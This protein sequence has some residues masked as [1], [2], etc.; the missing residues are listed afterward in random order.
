MTA[1]AGYVF[2]E[3]RMFKQLVYIVSASLLL[4]ACVDPDEETGAAEET[5]ETV[6]A[7][8][9]GKAD[10]ASCDSALFNWTDTWD[11]WTTEALDQCGYNDSSLVG[12]Y[13]VTRFD[14]ATAMTE[15]RAA[16]G[17]CEV[18]RI[19]ST[20]RE[21]GI[22]LFVRP[23][24]TVSLIR[25]V[26][27]DLLFRSG[28]VSFNRRDLDSNSLLQHLVVWVALITQFLGDEGEDVIHIGI[29]VAFCQCIGAVHLCSMPTHLISLNP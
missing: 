14:A 2:R 5:E 9:P 4:A 16:D 26:L 13:D 27:S 28:G 7:G 21:S 6:A 17:E 18:G 8:D 25:T 22:E 15:I 1:V 12:T 20:S 11:R 23:Q 24:R 3:V 19:Y 10:E 29:F